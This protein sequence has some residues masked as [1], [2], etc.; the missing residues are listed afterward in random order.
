MSCVIIV[1]SEG[2]DGRLLFERL[3][4]SGA[5]VVGVGRSTV[6]CANVESIPAVDI[7][8]SAAVGLM[9]DRIQP[10]E[11]YYLAAHH[12]SSQEPG[13]VGGADLLRRS[14]DVH[15]LGLANCLEAVR[16]HAPAAR[17]FYA[18]SSLVFGD[19]ASDPVDEETPFA[20]ACIY[21]ITKAA[22]IHLCRLY[23]RSH[24]VFAA[25]GLL[26]NHESPHRGEQF[27]SQKVVVAAT[28]IRAGRRDRLVLGDLSAEVDWGYA[29]DYVDA[30]LRV[31]RL[32]A[33]E[34][35]VIATGTTHTVREWVEAVFAAAGLD[36][37]KV[38]VE[39]PS[40]LTRRRP[41]VRGNPAKLTRATGW[42]PT[43]PFGEMARVMVEAKESTHRAS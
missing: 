39:D 29:P 43:M 6:R 15:V 28:E 18:G 42:R 9:V 1:G 34:D 20:P 14:L 10:T 22:G 4:G 37:R 26:F 3:A 25:C 33:A 21:G 19:P 35:F 31:L 5:G 7:L 13:L 2:Q 23:R 17:L 12:H 27:L 41:R 8:D 16:K 32:S 40:L 30:M 36:W 11:I 38:V 24:G